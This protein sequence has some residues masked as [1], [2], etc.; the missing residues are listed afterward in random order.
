MYQLKI[1]SQIT[2]HSIT[3][4]S[5]DKKNIKNTKL[6]KVVIEQDWEIEVSPF[7]QHCIIMQAIELK[8]QTIGKG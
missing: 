5:T 4:P 3:D 1:S 7:A 6:H 2:F 8:T